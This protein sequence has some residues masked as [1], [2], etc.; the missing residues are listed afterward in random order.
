LRKALGLL[1]KAQ[2]LLAPT[3]REAAKAL[4]AVAAKIDKGLDRG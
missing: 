1:R 4:A 2:S 3:H